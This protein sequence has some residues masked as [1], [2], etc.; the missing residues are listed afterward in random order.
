MN[1]V[2]CI[3]KQQLALRSCYVDK[4]VTHV[5]SLYPLLQKFITRVGR[6]TSQGAECSQAQT[7]LTIFDS[8][9]FVFMLHLMRTIL[10][11]P[12]DLYFAL[13]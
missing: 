12:T 3:K 13:L 2:M 1:L 11:Y 7:M 10:G 9:E 8:F 4:T 6:H 5:L